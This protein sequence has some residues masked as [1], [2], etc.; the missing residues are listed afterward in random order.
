M[1]QHTRRYPGCQAEGNTRA[2]VMWPNSRHLSYIGAC[3]EFQFC[4][5]LLNCIRLSDHLCVHVLLCCWCAYCRV[6]ATWQAPSLHWRAVAAAAV[7]RLSWR[8]PS[9]IAVSESL[10]RAAVAAVHRLC[11]AVAALLDHALVGVTLG[12]PPSALLVAVTSSWLPL[13]LA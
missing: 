1:P 8:P 7:M 2:A 12:R 4:P 13:S 3:S 11:T 10:D 9:L 6:P 5:S